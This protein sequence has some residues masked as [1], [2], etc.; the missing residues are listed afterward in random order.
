MGKTDKIISR[1]TYLESCKFFSNNQYGFRK[2]RSTVSAFQNIKNYIEQTSS[3]GNLVCIISID[4]K[5]AFNSVNWSIL[6]RKIDLPLSSYLKDVLLDFLNN[7]LIKNGDTKLQYNMGVPQRSCLGPLLWNIFINDLLKIE[8]DGGAIVQAFA[9][10]V[11]VVK[12]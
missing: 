1:R 12:G 9:D 5:N 3:E 6:R 11:G 8:F 2:Y 7:R 4:F 10:D